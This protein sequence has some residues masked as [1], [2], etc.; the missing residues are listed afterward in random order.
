MYKLKKNKV[1]GLQHIPMSRSIPP[2]IAPGIPW[3]KEKEKKRYYTVSKLKAN[4][5]T[6]QD[7]KNASSIKYIEKMWPFPGLPLTTTDSQNEME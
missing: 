4:L 7:Q 2:L 1:K 3:I 5:T 6:C